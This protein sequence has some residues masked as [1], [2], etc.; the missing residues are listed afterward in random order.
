M[1]F[2]LPGNEGA[3]ATL[4][5]CKRQSACSS[6]F[7]L[8]GRDARAELKASVTATRVL[9]LPHVSTSPGG[10]E[11]GS[12]WEAELAHAQG[13]PTGRRNPP[14]HHHLPSPT[15]A[16]P[17]RR[18]RDRRSGDHHH[19]AP[20]HQLHISNRFCCAAPRSMEAME[21]LAELAD[22]TL[23]GASL[24]ADDDPSSAD[25]R[26]ARRGSSFLTAVAIGNVVRT[27]YPPLFRARR[28]VRT[29]APESLIDRLPRVQFVQGSGKSAVLNGLIG[30]PVLVSTLCPD[31]FGHFFCPS[32]IPCM[33]GSEISPNPVAF[34]WM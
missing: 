6:V 20:P 29:C 8:D 18:S 4:Q 34:A 33:S 22:A 19:Q 11:R 2:C 21:E 7:L 32:C 14:H 31:I 10:R 9:C 12:R 30:H 13:S 27:L 5:I 25:D 3:T 23:Q 1:D 28:C 15:T 24:L 26:R 16:S 17:R